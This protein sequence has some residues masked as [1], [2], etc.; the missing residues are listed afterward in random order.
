MINK[1][2]IENPEPKKV[3]SVIVGAFI[4]NEDGELLL[5]KSPAWHNKYVCPGG[6]VEYN[7]AMLAAVIREAKEET[8]LDIKETE[9]ISCSEAVGIGDEFKKDE[10][11]LVFLNF[12]AKVSKDDN[13]KLNSESIS[14]KWLKPADWVKKDNVNQSTMDVI[15]KKFI[16]IDSCE[17]KYLRALADYQNLL[18]QSVRERQ[19]FVKYANEQM[20][21][22][23]IPV[24][25][26]LKI[27]LSH[28]DE[29]AS[30]NGWAEGI[31][32]VVK[33]FKDVL[34]GIGVEEIETVGKDFDHHTMEALDGKGDKVAKEVKS[35]YKLNGKLIIPAKVILE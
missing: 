1:T 13:I 5:I 11:H 2:N 6:H 10:K 3:P 32:Y 4:F 29:A 25:D 7:E 17:N 18:K 20:L 28:I 24:Y 27:S 9:L 22:D 23:L 34:Q 33:Q 16:N 21:Y 14:Y 19:E 26:N 30:Q 35:G 15:E 8:D 31:K 12:K